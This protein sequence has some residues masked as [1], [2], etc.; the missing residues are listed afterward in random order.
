[1]TKSTQFGLMSGFA[2]MF[3][4]TLLYVINPVLLIEGYERLTL[5]VFAGFILYGVSQKRQTNLSPSNLKDLLSTD[6][7]VENDFAPFGELL[8]FGFKIFVIG[9][10]I[11]FTFIYFLF[12]YYDPNLIELVKEASVKVFESYQN[13]AQDTQVIL[14]QKLAD[15][16]AQDFGPRLTDFLGMGLELIV[17]FLIALVIALFF[18]RERP[19]Y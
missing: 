15:Y 18:K 3:L 19:D 6:N 8:N 9:F 17:G 14:D 4:I 16:K 7:N 1:M 2:T 5:L 10:A 13:T 11:K 12:H